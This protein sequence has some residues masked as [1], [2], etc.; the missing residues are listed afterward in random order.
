MNLALQCFIIYCCLFEI[1]H[2]PDEH[3][4]KIKKRE[5]LPPL[6]NLRTISLC[7][8]CLFGIDIQSNKSND[9]NGRE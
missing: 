9:K 6:E 1:I 5:Q 4:V 3:W 8:L 7:L 2:L